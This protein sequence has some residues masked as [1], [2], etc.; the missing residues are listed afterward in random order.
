MKVA[1][2]QEATLRDTMDTMTSLQH[3]MFER[4]VKAAEQKKMTHQLTKE[5]GSLYKWLSAR[6]WTDTQPTLNAFTQGL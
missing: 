2:S 3:Q 4:Q 6:D 5:E 1:T